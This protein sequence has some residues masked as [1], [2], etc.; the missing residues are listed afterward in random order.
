MRICIVGGG[1]V[2]LTSGLYLA[3]RAADANNNSSLNL[4]S[5]FAISDLVDKATTMRDRS[6]DSAL[7]V[8]VLTDA[9][10]PNTTADGAAGIWG[11]YLLKDTPVEDQRCCN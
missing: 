2:G 11:P 3:R 1:I 8:T 5:D 6:T 9:T 4:D 10:T 7:E